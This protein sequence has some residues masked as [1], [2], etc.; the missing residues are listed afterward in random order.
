MHIQKVF[1]ILA[2]S[3][4][5]LEWIVELI[6]LGKSPHKLYTLYH[7]HRGIPYAGPIVQSPFSEFLEKQKA[8]LHRKPGQEVAQVR[9]VFCPH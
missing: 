3:E 2:F 1:V 8:N 5:H 9:A 4:H 7:V 6:G